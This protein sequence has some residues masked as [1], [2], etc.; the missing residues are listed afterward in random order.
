MLLKDFASSFKD[1]DQVIIPDIYKV[2]DTEEDVRSVNSE[3]LVDEIN[4]V[5]NNAQYIGSFK[6]VVK[7]LSNNVKEGD[8]VIIMGAGPVNKVGENFLLE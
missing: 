2:R 8:L 6:D 7:C 1:A 4:K 3:M 5:T